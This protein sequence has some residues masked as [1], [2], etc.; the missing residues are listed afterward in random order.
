[1]LDSRQRNAISRAL[2]TNGADSV[3]R[4][5]YGVYLVPS[6]SR[7]GVTHV[8]TGKRVDGADLACDCEAGT[9]GKP[10]HHAAAVMIAKVEHATGVR[11]VGPAPIPAPTA[12]IARSAT[13]PTRRVPLL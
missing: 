3:Q 2:E 9:F 4:I 13:A 1:M 7:E 8:V 10:C 12:V 5:E 11:V 6:H